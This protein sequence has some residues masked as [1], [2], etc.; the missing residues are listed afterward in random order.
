MSGRIHPYPVAPYNF[1]GIDDIS[2][3]NA[4]VVLLPVPYDSTT[5]Y[6]GGSKY[7]PDAVILASRE[8]ELYD[9]ELNVV[10]SD[11]VSILTARGVQ[12]DKSSPEKTVKRVQEVTKII[13]DAGKFPFILGGEHSIS[14]GSIA[15][16]KKKYPD[17]T[18]LQIDAH[19]DLRESWDEARYSH[20]AAMRRVRDLGIKTVHVGTRATGAEELEYIK[21]EKVPIFKAPFD[22][23][24]VDKVVNSLGKNVYITFDVDGLD[25]SIMPATG[26]PVPGGL[27]WK[28]ATTLLKAV[29][30]KRKVVG[31][32]VMELAPQSGNHAPDFLVAT[33]IYKI[34]G[35]VFCQ[36]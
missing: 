13:L 31:A 35:Y 3:D 20:A 1:L 32:D 8:L 2:M 33:L 22:I 28:E 19:S 5:S 18:V 6:K 24:D 34:V 4:K 11:E 17:L 23:K 7:G 14:A 36:K 30:Q 16:V 26:T 12:P 15:A 9:S 10:I 25:P 27:N 21:K 29:A